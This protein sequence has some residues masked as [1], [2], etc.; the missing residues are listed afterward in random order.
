[1]RDDAEYRGDFCITFQQLKTSSTPMIRSLTISILTAFICFTQ[2]LH[3]QSGDAA[4]TDQFFRQYA[5]DPM[6]AFDYAFSTNEWM[7]RNQDAVDNLKNQ[8]SN[9]LPLIGSYYGYDLITEKSMGDHLKVLSFMLRYDR[10]PIRL[11]F[12]MYKPKDRWQV[13]N[14]KYDDNLPEELEE[15]SKKN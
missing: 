8:Y 11:T 14:L 9:L 2:G 1:M 12:V 7:E 10:Q 6:K 4:I 15:A 5:L 3:A 13:Q